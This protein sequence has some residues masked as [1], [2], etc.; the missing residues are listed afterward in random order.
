MGLM[1]GKR[2][3][4]IMNKI[5]IERSQENKCPLCD[6]ELKD[7]CKI[8]DFNNKRVFICNHH[9]APKKG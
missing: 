3:L 2:F 7:D 6:R 1:A 5:I 8:E 4:F 9:P